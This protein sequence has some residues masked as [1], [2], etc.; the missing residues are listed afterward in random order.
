MMNEKGK[1]CRKPGESDDRGH[2]SIRVNGERLRQHLEEL[3]V[4]GRPQ[5]GSF[6]DGVNRIAFSDADIAGRDYVIKLMKAI[7]LDPR[8]DPAGNIFARREGSDPGLPPLLFGS[9]VDS[10]PSGG[11]FD[12]ALGSLAAIE[13]VET[14]HERRITTRHPLEVVVWAN[15]EGVAYGKPLYGSRVAAGKIDEEDLD[16]EWNGVKKRDAIRRIGGDPDRIRE[17]RRQPGSFAAYLEIHVEQGRTLDDEGIPIG[18]VEGIVGIDR[19][20]AV[21]RGVTNHAGT[22]RMADRHDALIAASHLILAINEIVTSESGNQVG[23]VGQL[24]VSPN[25]INL[26]PG[27]VRHSIELRDLSSEKMT[28]LGQRIQERA[29]S[30]EEK[31]RTKIEIQP[32]SHAEGARAA[33]QVQVAAETASERLGLKSRR[34][35]SAA[36][37]DAQLMANLGPMGMIFVPSIGGISHSPKELTQWEDCTGGADVLLQTVLEL[38]EAL[39]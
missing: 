25:A 27:L 32:T 17:A 38:D 14:L 6:A 12:G 36:G 5:G 39:D 20:E 21:I 24:S 18:I 28:Q 1:I 2:G 11:H 23:T 9:H 30:I 13:V 3:S 37:H 7:G 33:P 4:I 22:T 31:T 15:E 29:A 19:Y 16:E 26:V 35:P 10:V 8:I 34:L